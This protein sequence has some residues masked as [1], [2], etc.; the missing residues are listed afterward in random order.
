[1]RGFFNSLGY[2]SFILWQ[3]KIKWLITLFN[4]SVKNEPTINSELLAGKPEQPDSFD[5]D[6]R[7]IE[8]ILRLDI[9][10]IGN[11]INGYE[12]D[13]LRETIQHLLHRMK[14]KPLNAE[15]A[16]YL[17]SFVIKNDKIKGD[18]LRE[19]LLMVLDEYLNVFIKHHVS[20]SNRPK[21]PDSIKDEEIAARSRRWFAELIKS[22][23]AASGNP[24][25]SSA[26]A[27]M[28][29]KM[30]V[31]A[32]DDD[33]NE[34]YQEYIETND[35]KSRFSERQQGLYAEYKNL[36]DNFL[37][38]FNRRLKE[39]EDADFEKIDFIRQNAAAYATEEFSIIV[40]DHAMKNNG[41]EL[42]EKLSAG[43]KDVIKVA[44]GRYKDA[45]GVVAVERNI[46]EFIGGGGLD[47]RLV[48][49]LKELI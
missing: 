31:L 45:L 21:L 30:T 40:N 19:M 2:L 44:I 22:K 41:A 47:N 48:S 36:L 49:V 5:N 17:K 7:R 16:E 15:Q 46:N 14:E 37:N 24:N 3:G 23:Y 29:K 27:D 25:I 39:N 12:I 32:N 34:L 43:L 33:L 18:Y 1:L 20:P 10:K 11:G 42:K 13:N 9:D 35:T 4:M 6:V 28:L 38:E 26:V 8:D